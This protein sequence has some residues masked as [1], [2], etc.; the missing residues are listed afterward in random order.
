MLLCIA[1][2]EN[3]F[4]LAIPTPKE[5]ES[6]LFLLQ[7]LKAPGPNEFPIF[8]Y[9]QLWPTVGKDIINAVS[10]FFRLGSMPR[11]VN[12]TLIVL[13][14]K[15]SNPSIVNH[16]RPINL[17]NVV[18]KVISKILIAKLR[19]LLDKIISPSQSAFISDR[20]IAENQVIVQEMI[21]SFKTRKPKPGLMAI[22][23]YLQKAYDK[24]NQEF[25]K[26]ILLHLCFN[27]VF[28]SWIIAF[29]SSV[30]FKVLVNG[31][32]TEGFTPSRGL[33][34]GDPLP[35]YLF[36]LGQEI[37]SRMLEHERRNKNLNGIKTRSNGPNI[38]HLMYVDNIIMFSKATVRDAHCLINVLEKYCS[39]FGQSINKHKSGVFFSKHTQL[40]HH[41]TI[42]R[43]LQIKNLKRDA[44]YLGAP[45][46]LSRAPSKD[47]SFLQNKLEAKLLDWRSKC[48][49]WAG[50]KTLITSVAQSLPTYAMSTFSIPN[51]TCKKLDS[52][53]RRFWWKP[54][55]N[56][57]CYLAWKSW[58]KL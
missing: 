49:S 24:V 16:F 28:T 48:L 57:G 54:K 36:I 45:L 44:I 43:I 26:T 32:K 39:W 1:E 51:K 42:K 25:I 22:K 3:A 8:F 40:Q 2:E 29:I 50:R 21:H 55:A 38:S 7:D 15:V 34:Q 6:T 37:L 53:T 14:P 35:S 12:R 9:K 33:R 58:D 56:E 52:L 17:C 47:F 46:F 13:I 11:E 31:G 27:E 5:I 4:L 18:Y 20:Q 30:S 23:L 19:P 41:R 10:S